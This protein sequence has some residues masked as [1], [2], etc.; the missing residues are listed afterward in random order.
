MIELVAL[1]VRLGLPER[2]ARLV[3][4][5]AIVL[6]ALL[7][8]VALKGCYDRTVIE[9]HTAKVEARAAAARDRAADQRGR[10]AVID[11][12]NEKDLHDAIQRAPA[13][14]ELSPAAHAL[15]CERLR[16]L[17]RVPTACR[18]EGGDRSQADPR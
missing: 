13:G 10:D 12:A 6:A 1:L 5:P 18:H 8:L 14:G 16:K 3:A 9:R 4:W 2:L 15:A 11:A 7:A 17:G